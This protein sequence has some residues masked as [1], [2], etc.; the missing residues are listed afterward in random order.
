[1]SLEIAEIE[2]KQRL[3][4]EG[5]AKIKALGAH[6]SLRIEEDS[7]INAGFGH[8]AIRVALDALHAEREAKDAAYRER[9]QVVAALAR[10]FPSG[11]T[12]T[13]I[14]DW[15]PEWHGCVFIDLPTGQA[16]WHFHDDDAELFVGLPPYEK[17][18]DGHTTP[19]KY[20]RVAK[21]NNE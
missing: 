2:T 15:D 16:S 7:A 18:W 12:K 4:E 13:D 21:L 5:L 3:A 8:S 14:P 1:M 10:L 9:N 19:E 11:V 6:R 20:C 17:P